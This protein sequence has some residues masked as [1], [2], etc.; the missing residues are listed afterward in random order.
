MTRLVFLFLLLAS[1]AWGAIAYDTS[2]SGQI[3][4][5]STSLTISH[6]VAAGSNLFLVCGY[7]V[8]DDTAVTISTM[9]HNSVSMTAVTSS[10]VIATSA[11]RTVELFYLANPSS[12]SAYNAVF[13]FTNT[14]NTI[15]GGC[16]SFS[17]VHQSIPLGTAVTNNTTGTSSAV[18]ATSAADEI[19]IDF[20]VTSSDLT[21]RSFT[22]AA[23]QTSNWKQYDVTNV[24]CS[25]GSSREAGAATVAMGWS[26]SG[27]A[28]YQ[29]LSAVSI[30]P[31][32][33]TG[34]VPVLMQMNRRRR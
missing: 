1:P 2:S 23:G 32:A 14:I 33:A 9:T 10:K 13:T 26:W 22:Q 20:Q 17:G 18:T 16:S 29:A 4:T 8:Q 3:T 12:G 11:N 7:A 5:G 31:A 6:T 34:A 15:I 21:A 25:G 24:N 19:V 30:K 28:E 27:G